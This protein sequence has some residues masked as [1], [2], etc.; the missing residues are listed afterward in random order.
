METRAARCTKTESCTLYEEQS[1]TMQGCEIVPRTNQSC[2]PK[3]KDEMMR[4][5]Q[6]AH[7]LF[8]KSF[9]ILG[10]RLA[11]LMSR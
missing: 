3:W 9:A 6:S 7:L 10:W 4:S 5:L 1:C 11:E 8:R 2:R